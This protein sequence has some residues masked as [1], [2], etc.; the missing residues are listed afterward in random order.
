MA[1]DITGSIV[2]FWVG[3]AWS[4][5]ASLKMQYEQTDLGLEGRLIPFG[6]HIY[7]RFIIHS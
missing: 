6:R 5:E 7:D 3:D 1:M 2:D 4:L